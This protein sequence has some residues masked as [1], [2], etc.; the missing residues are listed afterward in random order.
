MATFQLTSNGRLTN[1]KEFKVEPFTIESY[2]LLSVACANDDHESFMQALVGTTNYTAEE[3]SLADL[4]QLAVYHRITEYPEA[5]LNLTWD[6]QG[7]F[8]ID[9]Q[10]NCYTHEE[11]EATTDIV[12]FSIVDCTTHNSV[13]FNMENFPFTYLGTMELDDDLSIPTAG[14]YAEYVEYSKDP[15]LALLIPAICWVKTDINTLDAKIKRV[16]EV[17]ASLFKKAQQASYRYQHG[18]RQKL[19]ASCVTCGSPVQKVV[20]VNQHSFFK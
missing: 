11:F 13:G 14:L 6:C 17:G 10:E 9:S 8:V 7:T 2:S 20:A 19:K 5:P 12:D 16:E 1:G 4:L 3:L 18:P 15:K